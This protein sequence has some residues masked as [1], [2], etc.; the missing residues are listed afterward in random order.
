MLQAASPLP[1][2]ARS[3]GARAA[4]PRPRR[5]RPHRP[6]AAWR[7]QGAAAAAPARLSALN[8]MLKFAAA[9]MPASR[10]LASAMNAASHASA[11]ARFASELSIG[12]VTTRADASAE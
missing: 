1:G 4:P 9:A 3:Q 11:A 6:R 5:A 7:S 12:Y 2:T 8:A 10:P